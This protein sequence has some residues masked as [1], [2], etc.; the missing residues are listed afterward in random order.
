MTDRT[1]IPEDV[2]DT[3][4]EGSCLCAVRYVAA[5]VAGPMVHCH[6]RMCRKT[7]GSTFSTILPVKTDGF[8]WTFGEELLS[9]FESSPGKRRWFCRRCGSPLI[10]TRDGNNES[11]LL[12]DGGIDRGYDGKPVAHGWVEFMAPW[13][14]ITDDLPQFARGFP[15]APPGVE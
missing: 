6:C 10:S 11:L 5:H 7:H 3:M 12:R 1:I 2:D 15:G 14:Q 4:I 9:H 8:R 13:Y